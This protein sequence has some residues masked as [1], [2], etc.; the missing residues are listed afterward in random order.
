MSFGTVQ[1]R[2]NVDGAGAPVDG[3]TETSRSGTLLGLLVLVLFVDLVVIAV[4]S[5]RRRA[6]H[7]MQALRG[8]DALPVTVAGITGTGGEGT[9][10]ATAVEDVTA[11]VTELVRRP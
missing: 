10:P 7:R 6:R 8:G 3:F 9:V 1:W 4:R 2:V 11:P 5:V